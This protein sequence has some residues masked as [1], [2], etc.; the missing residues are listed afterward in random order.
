ML[1]LDS[2]PEYN[3]SM[4]KL[5]ILIEPLENWELFEAGFPEF[6][7]LAEEMPGLLR[8][9][10]GRVEDHLYG[11][12]RVQQVHELYFESREAAEKAMASP[13]GR[14]A[15]RLLQRIT[16]GHVVLFFSDHMEDELENIRLYKKPTDREK[17][18][19]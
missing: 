9:T 14:A 11:R 4:H 17:E 1:I 16:D 19:D 13:T 6:L 18:K 8:E 10:I 15:G 3:D 2:F 12:F 5:V 7:H